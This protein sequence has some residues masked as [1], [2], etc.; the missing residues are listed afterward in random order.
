MKRAA[1]LFAA[2]TLTSLA[3]AAEVSPAETK[4]REGLRNTML[5]LR[6]V[7]SEKGVLEAAKAE[8]E[9]KNEEVTAKLDAMSKELEANRQESEKKIAD[10]TERIVT[11]GNDVMKIEQ[12]LDKSR[13]AHKEA[14]ALATRK[15]AGTGKAC[16]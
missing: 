8:L 14:S 1:L 15:E 3:N 7:Q 12:E 2:V 5:Q 4:L 16:K 11:R 9:Q 6:T 13:A 10:L